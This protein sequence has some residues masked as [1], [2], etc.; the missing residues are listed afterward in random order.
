MQDKRNR[1]IQAPSHPKALAIEA[2]QSSVSFGLL[3]ESNP[4]AADLLRYYLKTIRN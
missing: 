3:G 2:A 4:V 1:E